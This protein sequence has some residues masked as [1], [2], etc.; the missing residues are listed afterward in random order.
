[1][2][3]D[4]TRLTSYSRRPAAGAAADRMTETRASAPPLLQQSREQGAGIVLA[5]A[6]IIS[7]LLGI[8]TE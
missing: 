1:M 4:I 5:P 2:L 8:V 6:A 3:V 7:H